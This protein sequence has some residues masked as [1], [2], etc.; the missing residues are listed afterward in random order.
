MKPEVNREAIGK[1]FSAI[2]ISQEQRQLDVVGEFRRGLNPRE[3]VTQAYVS[4]IERGSVNFTI[5]NFIEL[6]RV[7]KCE[8]EQVF[9]IARRYTAT[10]HLELNEL[11]R[12][13][14]VTTFSDRESA[15]PAALVQDDYRISSCDFGPL[16][17]TFRLSRGITLANIRDALAEMKLPSW[18]KPADLHSIESGEARFGNIRLLDVK[19]LA[20]AYGMSSVLL[21]P[22]LSKAVNGPIVK[23]ALDEFRPVVRR[24]RRVADCIY[25]VPEQ[26]LNE[27]RCSVSLLR[28]RPREVSDLHSHAGVELI[29]VLEGA[30]EFHLEE[31]GV[32]QRLERWQYVLFASDLMHKVVNIGEAEATYFVIRFSANQDG[33]MRIKARKY[34]RRLRRTIEKGQGSIYG[35][36][37]E[38]LNDDILEYLSQLVS[39]PSGP[40]F[41]PRE[42]FNWGGLSSFIRSVMAMRSMTSHDVV[43]KLTAAGRTLT[44]KEAWSILSGHEIRGIGFQDIN[45]LADAIEVP[46]VLLAPFMFP[47]VPGCAV[48]RIPDDLIPVRSP[49][50]VDGKVNYWMPRRTLAGS[51]MTIC[52]LV[53]GEREASPW[54]DHPGSELAFPLC[55]RISV[56]L[57]SHDKHVVSPYEYAHFHSSRPHRITNVSKGE[58][59]VLV[60][61]MDAPSEYDRP[62]EP[63]QRRESTKSKGRIGGT[64]AMTSTT[65][66][67]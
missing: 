56:E 40:V 34:I 10:K 24:D 28:L 62:S 60:V 43:S 45:S 55:G 49:P 65:S 57:G 36:E 13:I 4:R 61:R 58:A 52:V 51:Q 67:E 64:F 25:H 23:Q 35:R 59:K 41:E 29:F 54:N 26:R 44:K 18:L 38:F 66:W 37:G 9:A 6:C 32:Q 42:I 5:D 21:D 48:V 2:R 22:L 30:I 50:D 20:R 46:S 14:C 16:L 53:L 7:L 63:A 39:A 11:L 17:K 15:P 19:V 8:P 31:I 3:H 1:A 27:P 12:D 47:A 33:G